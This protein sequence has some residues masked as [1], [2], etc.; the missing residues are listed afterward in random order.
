M[1]ACC[2]DIVK[3]HKIAGFFVVG[4]AGDST[5]KLNFY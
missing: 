5:D 2:A 1:A 4:D 3:I